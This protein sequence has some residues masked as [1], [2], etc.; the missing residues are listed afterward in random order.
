MGFELGDCQ[1]FGLVA[2]L[3]LAAVETAQV[4]VEV[5][6]EADL[7]DILFIDRQILAQ[8]NDVKISFESVLVTND[9]EWFSGKTPN[10]DSALVDGDVLGV[11]V[12]L[13]V[14]VPGFVIND[15]ERQP[16]KAACCEIAL[17]D[18]RSQMKVVM[19]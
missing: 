14:V 10:D 12:D 3:V 18:E 8:M 1:I 15:A 6:R 13:V 2:N 9:W 17:L 11:E 16:D 5:R 7:Q 4:V 19:F